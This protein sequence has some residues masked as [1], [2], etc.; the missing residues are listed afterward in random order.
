MFAVKRDF[1]VA[2]RHGGDVALPVSAV[3]QTDLRLPVIF[4][5][6]GVRLVRRINFDVR[7]QP[8]F[9]FIGDGLHH[10]QDEFYILLDVFRDPPRASAFH[11]ARTATRGYHLRPANQSTIRGRCLTPFEFRPAC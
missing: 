5:N 3:G 7:E 4:G 1:S 8:V 6:Y 11:R 9:R 10:A 2:R